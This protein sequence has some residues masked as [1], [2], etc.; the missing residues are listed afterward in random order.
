MFEAST[1]MPM[2]MFGVIMGPAWLV[3]SAMSNRNSQAEE[4]LERLGRPKSLAEIDI[5]KRESEKRERFSGLKKTVEDFGSVLE[6]HSEL[7]KNSLK[8]RLANAGFRSESA[9]AVFRGLRLA[10]LAM[11][12]VP[13]FL[14]ALGMGIGTSKGMMILGAGVGL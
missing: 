14:T 12:G 6:P 11:L 1:L 2:V 10:A 3:L 7:E 9:P 13:A 8:I 4:R 5:T